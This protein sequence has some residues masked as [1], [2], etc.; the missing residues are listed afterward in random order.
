MM[1]VEPGVRGV[2]WP[3]RAERERTV[4]VTNGNEYK[5]EGWMFYH[6]IYREIFLTLVISVFKTGNQNINY[7]IIQK[8]HFLY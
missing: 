5:H 1:A 7:I 6:L 2:E 4:S 3:L 8:S